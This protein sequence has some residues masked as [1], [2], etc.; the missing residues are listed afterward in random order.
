MKQLFYI[1]GIVVLMI[2]ANHF[3]KKVKPKQENKDNHLEEN[4]LNDEIEDNC[5]T[6][7]S[8]NSED[9]PSESGDSETDR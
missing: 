7:Y 9:N 5:D 1:I 4:S 6:E 3:M 8:E 2:V